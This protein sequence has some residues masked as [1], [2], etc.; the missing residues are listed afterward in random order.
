[1]ARA[2]RDHEDE[3]AQAFLSAQI[4]AFAFVMGHIDT[5][6][7]AEEILDPSDK[8][9]A[10]F[11]DTAVEKVV[12]KFAADAPG[13]PEEEEKTENAGKKKKKGKKDK[14]SKGE[15]KAVRIVPSNEIGDGDDQEES[16]GQ[17]EER[18]DE[19]NEAE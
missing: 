15:K 13:E 18:D 8:L 19:Q 10:K 3:K 11:L 2:P 1:M 5:D 9:N 4:M 14:K 6:S 17:E 12:E 7:A 16:S